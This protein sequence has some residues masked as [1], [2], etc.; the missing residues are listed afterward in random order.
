MPPQKNKQTN[1]QQTQ[2]QQQQN[3]NN[4]Q[5]N[6]HTT[7]F[8]IGFFSNTM[9]ARYFKFCMIVTLL[10][11]YI[12]IIGLITVTLFEGHR[13][14]RN[15][16]CELRVLYSCPLLFKHCMFATYITKIRRSMLCVTG[17][18]L[19]DITDTFNGHIR[20]TEWT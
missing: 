10:E 14:F 13:C 6:K 5:T 3:N 17:V 9:K 2:Q 11:V 1:K 20:H 12:A 7:P 19:M 4:K 16:N 8:N 15:I 18:Y